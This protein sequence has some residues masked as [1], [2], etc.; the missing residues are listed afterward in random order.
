[1]LV[2]LQNA[3]FGLQLE[4]LV[5]LS[6]LAFEGPASPYGVSFN[7]SIAEAIRYASIVQPSMAFAMPLVAIMARLAKFSSPERHYNGQ[8]RHT[9]P[10]FP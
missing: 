5:I 7:S 3:G 9:I 1:R 6:L 10:F 8:I 2:E 4:R